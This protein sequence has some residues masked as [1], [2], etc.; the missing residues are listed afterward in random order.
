[1]AALEVVASCARDRNQKGRNPDRPL[2]ISVGRPD[3]EQGKPGD[4][5]Q[6]EIDE[7]ARVPMIVV[8]RERGWADVP[9][10]RDEPVHACDLFSKPYRISALPEMQIVQAIRRRHSRALR[11]VAGKTDDPEKPGE[12][13]TSWATNARDRS[14][15]AQSSKGK[16]WGQI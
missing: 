7:R 16:G 5:W 2:R 13:D 6:D 11:K 12:A 15:R 1:M 3:G 10:L 9:I 4:E 14:H 8:A